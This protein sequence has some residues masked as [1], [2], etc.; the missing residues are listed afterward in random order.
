[1]KRCGCSYDYLFNQ[2]CNASSI[3]APAASPVSLTDGA[4]LIIRE[5]S[6]QTRERITVKD[7]GSL[8]QTLLTVYVEAISAG[9]SSYSKVTAIYPDGT[10]F[11]IDVFPPTF[12]GLGQGV[13]N[14]Y[15]QFPTSRANQ[16][17]GP[18][19]NFNGNSNDDPWERDGQLFT[20]AQLANNL[21][22]NNRFVNSWRVDV[23][24]G[25]VDLFTGEGPEESVPTERPATTPAAVEACRAA[26]FSEL[27][28]ALFQA[29]VIDNSNGIPISITSIHKQ[30]V[31]KTPILVE[32]P[33]LPVGPVERLR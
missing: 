5:G 4:G 22:A 17:V 26:G 8:S 7:M 15:V 12:P 33:R 32:G 27:D 2:P 31:R 30:K 13:L 25:D 28:G 3:F 14:V 1:M 29:C 18:I 20:Y 10:R 9:G 19:G 6:P 11:Q 23:S 21:V 16:I 24:R